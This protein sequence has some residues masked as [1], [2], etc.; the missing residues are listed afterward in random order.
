VIIT[1][2]EF[3]TA[4]HGMEIYVE[5]GIALRLVI[6]LAQKQIIT[7]QDYGTALHGME[8]HVITGTAQHELL[9]LHKKICTAQEVGIAHHL[10]EITATTGDAMDGQQEQLQNMIIT[11]TDGTAQI[12]IQQSHAQDGTVCS[13][14][15]QG[16]LTKTLTAQEI[17]AAQHGLLLMTIRIQ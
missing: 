10:M 12:L 13:G 15:I 7:V 2:L 1:V 6:L 14:L 9:E 16:Q 17:G 4:L 5:D 8:T 11:A 3:G